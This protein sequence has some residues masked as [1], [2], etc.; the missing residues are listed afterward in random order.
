M[1]SVH[2]SLSTPS[3][4]GVVVKPK[5]NPVELASPLDNAAAELI[6][7]IDNAT[8]DLS[9]SAIEAE[10]EAQDAR[11][12]ARAALEVARR[13]TNRS[14]P[15]PRKHDDDD[16][17]EENESKDPASSNSSKSKRENAHKTTSHR[18]EEDDDKS[19]HKK[20][21]SPPPPITSQM[22]QSHAEDV[23]TLSL[24]LEKTKS[25]LAKEEQ[26]HQSTK[27]LLASNQS[28]DASLSATID[29]MKDQFDLEKEEWKR[30]M[31]KLSREN[32]MQRKKIEAAE[33]DASLALELAKESNEEK[34]KMEVY[35]Q[36]ALTEIE[37]LKR[38]QN[39]QQQVDVP[40]S[41]HE[42]WNEEQQQQQPQGE[43]L[44]SN[45]L[46]DSAQLSRSVFQTVIP[47]VPEEEEEE[48]E[49]EER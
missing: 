34:E 47:E 25:L 4:E 31:D 29:E 42:H 49:E 8:I 17:E 12:N 5:T 26:S 13:Y 3:E 16:E 40:Q 2:P 41:Q 15:N 27:S 23:L 20:R 22:A 19:N 10:Y 24:E 39:Q 7:F 18:E 21:K 33:E 14:Y 9:A 28:K 11:K 44:A 43:Y 30:Q 48:E 35:L 45:V 37:N 46:F 32:R 38:N 6:S 1:A 36:R